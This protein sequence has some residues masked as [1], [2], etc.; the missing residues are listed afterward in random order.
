MSEYNCE[1]EPSIIALF[2]LFKEMAL[3]LADSNTV[4]NSDLK[5]LYRRA[6]EK[7]EL[8]GSVMNLHAADVIRR[9]ILEENF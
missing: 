5:M 8:A 1:C 7:Q 6:L 9:V 2:S 4:S 3:L